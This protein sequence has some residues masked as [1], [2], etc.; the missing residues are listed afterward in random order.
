[1]AFKSIIG[2]TCVCL[3][4]VSFSSNAALIGRLA[5]TEG[6]TD[7]Q[8]Y[9]DTEADLTW[10]ADANVNGAMNWADANAWTAGLDVDGVTGWRLPDTLQPDASCGTH[11]HIGD[12]YCTTE[13]GQKCSFP[14]FSCTSA[15]P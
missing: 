4:V 5:A 3:T 6:G 12:D 10:L 15:L 7:Y 8:A 14:D 1:M 11:H 13:F 2:A 9:Y